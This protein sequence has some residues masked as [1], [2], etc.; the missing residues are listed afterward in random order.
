MDTGIYFD[1]D[2]LEITSIGNG[3]AL[4]PHRPWHQVSDD[5][6]LR[7]TAVRTLLINR[8]QIEEHQAR[9]VY[10]FLEQPDEEQLPPRRA[11]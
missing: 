9:H 3:T 8:G 7:L 11:A 2:Q 1:P 6:S 10:W 5:P 4:P